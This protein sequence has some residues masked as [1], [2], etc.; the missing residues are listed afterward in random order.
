M[1]WS[2]DDIVSLITL[3][4]TIPTFILAVLGLVRCYRRKRRRTLDR[5]GS[6]DGPLLQ[7]D[8]MPLLSTAS[9]P[10]NQERDLEMGWIEFNH[11]TMISRTG[12]LRFD[13]RPERR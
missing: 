5:S 10:T 3:C 13:Q 4:I 1:S 11:V 8:R 6:F 12:S 2:V 7:I 9:S